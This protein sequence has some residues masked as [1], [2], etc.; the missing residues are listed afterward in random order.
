MLAARSTP[1]VNALYSRLLALRREHARLLLAPLSRDPRP[2]DARLEWLGK[3]IARGEEDLLPLLPALARS[4]QL[5]RSTPEQLQKALPARSAFVDLLR[6]FHFEQNPRVKGKKGEQRTARYVAF[7]LTRDRLT[8]VDLG[9]ARAVEDA[10]ALWR[11]SLIEGGDAVEK[12]GEEVRRL[13]WDRLAKE[14]KGVDTVYLAPDAHLTQL[15]WAALPGDRLGTV[16]L[17]QWAFAVVPHGAFLLDRLTASP[18]KR[19]ERPVLLAVGGVR[20]NDLP[21]KLDGKALA[22]LDQRARAAGDD[23]AGLK[24]AY[25]EGTRTELERVTGLARG[26]TARALTGAEACTQ[27]LLVELPQAHV[28]H[29]ATHGFFADKK[30]RSVLQLDETLFAQTIRDDGSTAQRI[31]AGSRSP[32]VLSGLVLAG[33][34]RADTPDRGILS[35]DDLVGLDLRKLELTVLSACETGLGEVGGGEGVFGLQR[36]FILPG[37]AMWWLPCGR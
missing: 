13:V 31:G 22:A 12:H 11:R 9:E 15:P 35:A 1:R 16:L 7:V 21:H 29:L 23:K 10:L 27:R 20:Y 37:R 17:E 34:N 25:L 19:E 26:F 36:A 8:R 5:A 24:W 4:E 28:A 32:L 2:R 18:D 3:E 30:F 14:L 33:A 6:Y